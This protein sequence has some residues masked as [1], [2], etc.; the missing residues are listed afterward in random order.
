MYKYKKIMSFGD[1][2]ISTSNKCLYF[3]FYIK[4]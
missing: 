2:F 1:E 3:G 4:P